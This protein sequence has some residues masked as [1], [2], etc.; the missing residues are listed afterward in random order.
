MRNWKTGDRDI[1]G[2]RRHWL[3]VTE[4]SQTLWKCTWLDATKH[5]S[6]W[7]CQFDGCSWKSRLQAGLSRLPLA[8]S[9]CFWVCCVCQFRHPGLN[10]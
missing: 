8:A 3:C 10:P 5:Y 1:C 7:T 9:R 6:C 4:V 2:S